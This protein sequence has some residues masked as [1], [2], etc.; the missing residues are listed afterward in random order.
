MAVD[1]NT[2]LAAA[3]LHGTSDYQQRV[4]SATQ[5][6]VQGVAEYLFA[7]MNRQYLNQFANF[8]INRIGSHY[9]R[10]KEFENPLGFLKN[11][12]IPFGQ[13]VEETALKWIK[14]HSYNSDDMATET[15]L[16]THYPEGASAFHSQNRRDRYPIS[17]SW[18]DLKTAFTSDTGLNDFIGAILTVPRNSDNYDEYKIML[19]LIAEFEAAHGIRK[20]LVA[21]PTDEASSKA[22][23][24]KLRELAG[25]LKFPSTLY[26][27]QD[28]DGIPVFASPEE[29]ILFVT[30]A[31]RAALDVEG[32]SAVFQLDKAD[33][34]YRIVDVDVLPIPNCVAILAAE[35]WFMVND[36]V[37]ETRTFENPNSLVTTSW[38]HH[39]GIYSLS[40]FVPVVALMTD[41]ATATPLITQTVTGMTF[42]APSEVYLNSKDSAPRL[43]VNLTGT[44]SADP[45]D[46]VSLENLGVKPDSAIFEVIKAVDSEGNE[47]NLA[48]GNFAIWANG[49]VYSAARGNSNFYK[50]VNAGGVT[51]TVK[52]TATY[53]DPS[54]AKQTEYTQEKDV[55]VIAKPAEA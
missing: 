24:R 44:I 54:T 55:K 7:P 19:N 8:L 17:W 48:E 6:G 32:L 13:T 49:E 52:A 30:P 1:N 41:E 38:L 37:Y 28:V 20:E 25:L 26:T 50:A 40:P 29:L 35:D 16:K 9:I 47:L 4:P 21:E 39:W 46:S 14:A 36:T 27:A 11:D 10:Q 18:Q 2:I 45:A 22:L 31:T 12:M 5:A 53:I 51:V 43:T 33:V 34:P 15:M 23:L 42:E 3:R